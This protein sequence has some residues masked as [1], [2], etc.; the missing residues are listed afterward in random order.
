MDRERELWEQVEDARQQW[1]IAHN[2][3]THANRETESNHRVD[4]SFGYRHAIHDE[5]LAIK[6]YHRALREYQAAIAP[7]GDETANGSHGITPRER[8]VLALIASGK[9][10]KEIAAE[11]GMAFRTAVC[12][13]Y[14]L[15]RKLNVHTNVELTRAAM[16]M[17]LIEV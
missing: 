2:Q 14:R 8:E 17:G 5:N 1:L 13:R 12:H 11:L 3:V 7:A 4:G 15:Y 9:S 16:R 6:N 10:S